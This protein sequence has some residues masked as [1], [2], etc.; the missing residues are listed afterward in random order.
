MMMGINDFNLTPRAKKAYKLAKQ[1]ASD[2]GHSL[3][4]NSHVFYGCLAN[5]ADSFWR[6]VEKNNINLSIDIYIEIFTKLQKEKPNFFKANKN[7]GNWHQEVNDVM[8]AAKSFSEIY[9]NYYIGSEHI[10]YSILECSSFF[11]EYLFKSGVDTEKLKSMI[12]SLIVDNNSGQSIPD[13]NTSENSTL[14]SKSLAK[15][16][17]PLQKY[18]ICLNDQVI[19]NS[20]SPISGREK[21]IDEL[22]ETLSKKTKS[23]AILVGDAGVGKTAVVEGLAQRIVQNKVP[24]NL[25][26]FEIHC[27]DIASMVAGTRYRGEFE[28]KFKSLIKAA[29]EFKNIILFFD[30]IHTIIGTGS[31]EGSLDAANMLKPEL[32]RGAIKCIGATTTSE[33]KKF[34]EKD[35]A[36]KRRFDSI[37]IDEPD[38]E[39][40]KKIIQNAIKFY[41][42]FHFVKYEKEII[43]LIVDLC[44]KYISD[45][46]FPDKAFDIIDQVGAKVKVNKLKLPS[47]IQKIQDEISSKLSDDYVLTNKEEEIFYEILLREYIDK[48]TLFNKNILKNKFK[49]KQKDVLDVVS[50]KINLPVSSICPETDE[51]IN[52]DQRMKKDIFGQN[53]NIDKI[54]DILACA[55]IGLNDDKKPL[56]NLFFVGPTSVGKTY[57][58]KKIAEHYFGNKKAFIQIN[59]SEYQEKTGISKLIGANAGY[60]GYEEGGL[61]TEFVRNNPNCVVLFDEIEKCDPQILNLLLH[62]LDEGYVNDNLNRKIDFTKSIIVMTSNIGHQETKKKTLGFIQEEII[63]NDCYTESVKKYLKPE[64]ISRINELLIFDDLNDEQLISIVHLE[65]NKIKE[66]L[67]NKNFKLVFNKNVENFIFNKFK[68]KKLHA[69]DIKDLVR[70]ELQVPIARFIIKNTNLKKVSIKV[71]DN[72]L[73]IG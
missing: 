67:N 19:N 28:E 52:F 35:S 70:S 41:E 4:N 32:A 48:V 23:N 54:S 47:D 55:K 6:S 24:T 62:L 15:K 72:E 64:L 5:A 66:K 29:S 11:S 1:F 37:I 68:S 10:I 30:E 51:F 7:S 12:E 13:T 38:K 61:L 17:E 39:Q 63:N 14:D 20:I 49:I 44:D 40:T 57:T 9:D 16:Y 65:I 53:K 8:V 46:K 25:S 22:I 45:K 59:M 26:G 21:E 69:R 43:D 36:M 2:N 34:F 73:I 71:I 58:A 18:C 3:I 27:V 33:Y 42:N 31:A 60:I 56:C 50:S